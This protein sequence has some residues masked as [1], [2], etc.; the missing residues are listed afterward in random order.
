MENFKKYKRA[1][2][3]KYT[4]ELKLTEGVDKKMVNE[5]VENYLKDGLDYKDKVCLDLGANVGG[6]VKLALDHGANKVIAV[7]C[8]KRNFSILKESF[9]EDE[10][11]L[12]YGAVIGS[13]QP[14]VE[15]YKSNSKNNHCSTSI[16]NKHRFG[17]YDVVPT[18]DVKTLLSEYKPD[19]VKID[20]ESAEYTFIDDVIDYLPKVLFIELHGNKHKKQME[21]YTE[22]LKSKYTNSHIEPLIIFTTNHIANDCFFYNN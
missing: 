22:I 2:K 11:E 13:E 7:D 10:V 9:K 21:K 6:F 18:I 16:F 8:D 17:S 3:A 19:I 5:S 15:I 14:V 20:V 12:I 4:K 1:L